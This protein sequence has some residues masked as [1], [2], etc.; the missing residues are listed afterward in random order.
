MSN[1]SKFFILLIEKYAYYRGMKG[2]EV[3]ALFKSHQLIDYIYDMYELYHVEDLHN[4]FEDLDSKL[5]L[6]ETQTV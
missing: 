4:A 6:A 5:V 3:L 2:H 1:E